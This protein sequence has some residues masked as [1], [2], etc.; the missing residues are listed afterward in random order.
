MATRILLFLL[1]N[2]GA[3]A[4]GG[5]A[6]GTGVQSDWYLNLNKAPWTPPGWVFGAAWT[7]IMVCFSLYMAYLW[8]KVEL[9]N[10]L[11]LLYGLQLLLNVAWNPTFFSLQAVLPA[12]ILILLLTAL[13]T[14]FLL[15]YWSILKEKSLLIAP[16]ALWLCIAT[17]L[18]IFVLVHN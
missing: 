6:T 11:I 8:P 9:K 14:Y 4:I 2:F 12:L 16:Y 1:L 17:S 3:L 13:V 15:T 7:T 18:N 5:L 10:T